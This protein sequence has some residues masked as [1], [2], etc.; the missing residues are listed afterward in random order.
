MEVLF[1]RLQHH[2]FWCFVRPGG[3]NYVQIGPRIQNFTKILPAYMRR[4]QVCPETSRYKGDFSDKIFQRFS[5][6]A[7]AKF[8]GVRIF[9]DVYICCICQKKN[10]KSLSCYTIFDSKNAESWVILLNKMDIFF[11][12]IKKCRKDKK[13]FYFSFQPL[14]TIL[15]WDLREKIY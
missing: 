11:L 2:C 1:A 9:P 10:P 8:G 5:R 13:T 7:G 12:K 6:P 4:S 14:I 3:L 15:F